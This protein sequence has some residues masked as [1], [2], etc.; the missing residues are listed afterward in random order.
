MVHEDLDDVE[1]EKTLCVLG[2]SRPLGSG[3]PLSGRRYFRSAIIE[4]QACGHRNYHMANISS[5]QIF[6]VLIF[7]GVDCPR[8]LVP[9]ENFC[10][11]SIPASTLVRT[12]SISFPRKS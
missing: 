2:Y 10:V 12:K 3:R 1:Y 6:V 4:V 8:K 11:Y 5:V 9:H 7:V